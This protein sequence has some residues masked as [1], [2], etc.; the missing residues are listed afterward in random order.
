[1][2]GPRHPSCTAPSIMDRKK[3]PPV[4]GYT[5]DRGKL[6]MARRYQK[7]RE[8][9]P[10]VEKKLA[11]GMG[12]R[13]IEKELELKGDRPIHNLL[14]RKGRGFY[15]GASKRLHNVAIE[16]SGSQVLL[17]HQLYPLF[18]A[19]TVIAAVKRRG[20]LINPAKK[21]A[22]GKGLSLVIGFV[23]FKDDIFRVCV[24]S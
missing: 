16:S 23:R 20:S 18:Y 4:V 3:N 6:Y 19:H 17:P 10:A 9:L 5:Y 22:G 15:R 7:I 2:T 12:H 8:L 1:M 14:K 11:C 13:E 24:C 21:F